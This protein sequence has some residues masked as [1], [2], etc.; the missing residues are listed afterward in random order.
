MSTPKGAIRKNGKWVARTTGAE[1]HETGNGTEYSWYAIG[2]DGKAYFYD[3]RTGK[4]TARKAYRPT[5]NY[6]TVKAQE[7]AYAKQ[8]TLRGSNKYNSHSQSNIQEA[9][10]DLSNHFKTRKEAFD[11]AR[12]IGASGFLWQGG[13]YNTRSAGETVDQQQQKMKQNAGKTVDP[14]FTTGAYGIYN[15]GKYLSDVDENGY[16]GQQKMGN[17][18][19]EVYGQKQDYTPG[20]KSGTYVYS[21]AYDPYMFGNIMGIPSPSNQIGAITRATRGEGEGQTWGQRYFDNLIGLTSST[22]PLQN[23]GLASISSSTE[24]IADEHPYINAGINLV[25]DAVVFGGP[26]RSPQMIIKGRQK[27]NTF[28][29]KYKRIPTT[30]TVPVDE[31]YINAN[32]FN[33]NAGQFV[34]TGETTATIKGPTIRVWNPRSEWIPKQRTR[35]TKTIIPS[36]WDF[37]PETSLLGGFASINSNQDVFKNNESNNQ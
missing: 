36:S 11:Y 5:N 33:S 22:A 17:T 24:A 2:K 29:N 16:Y 9:A 13:T 8:N 32:P 34:K 26:R 6:K 10:A 31:G 37:N 27:Y 21:S 12:S 35:Y 14:K 4:Y 28:T 15:N 18:R 7:A 1:L 30:V 25:T 20:S 3:P 23:R 19:T